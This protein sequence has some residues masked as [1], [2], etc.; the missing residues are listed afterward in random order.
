MKAGDT[1]GV[2]TLVGDRELGQG[3]NS[4]VWR[5]EG[6]SHAA[7]AIK[8]L[9]RFDQYDRFR[10]EVRF[11]HQMSS[12]PG[13]L[14]LLDFHLPDPPSKSDRPWLATPI[15]I[16]V[17]EFVEQSDNKLMTAVQ[18]VRDAAQVLADLHAENTAHRDIKPENLFIYNGGAVLGDFGLVTYLGKEA[19]TA[20]GERLGPIYYVA[21]EL[22]GNEDG[23]MRT[24]SPDRS[25]IPAHRLVAWQSSRAKTATVA[26]PFFSGQPLRFRRRPSKQL[27]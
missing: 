17:R 10:D 6:P 14:P 3:G 25:N 23:V 22:L 1:Y 27:P 8:F 4:I 18:L 7:V 2:W 16:G 11:Q 20:T 9:T 15:S 24:Y 12:R 5:A 13:V 19:T 26:A 21:P